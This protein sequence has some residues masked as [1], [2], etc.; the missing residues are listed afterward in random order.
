MAV[1]LGVY[2]KYENRNILVFQSNS[3]TIFLGISARAYLRVLVGFWQN[4]SLS[5]DVLKSFESWRLHGVQNL[6]I[7]RNTW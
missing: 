6:A 1:D 2:K 7:F 3:A 5:T 4:P